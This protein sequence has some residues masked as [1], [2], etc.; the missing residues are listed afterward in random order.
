M[1]CRL[2]RFGRLL[3]ITVAVVGLFFNVG[4]GAQENGEALRA[5]VARIDITPE[6]PVKMSGYASRTSLS[7]GVHDPLSA[8]AIALEKDGRRLVLVNTDLIGFYNG[9]SDYLRRALLEELNLKPAELMLSAIHTHSAPS[10]TVDSENGH[11]NNLEYT[12][13]LK[14]KLIQLIREAQAKMGPV[15]MGA[16]VGYSPVGMNRRQTR[17]DGIGKE[18]V[19]YVRLGR[20]PYGPTDKEVL[21]LKIGEPDKAPK[22]VMFSYSTH[23]TSLGPR[24][25]MIGGDV[26]GLAEQFAEKIVGKGV[27][28]PGFA[29]ASGDI[30]PWF[31][32]LPG[33]NEEEGWI[34]EPVLLGTLLGEEVVHV[35]RSIDKLSPVGEINSAFVELAVPGKPE[36][37]VSVPE[38]HPQSV[39][40]LTVARVGDIAFVG[41]GGEVFSEIGLAV[42][43]ASPFRHTFV[44]TH[45]NGAAG[46]LPMAKYYK[47]GGYEVRSSSFAPE[48]AELVKK[49]VLEMLYSL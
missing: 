23:A 3:T 47:E 21:V 35:Y 34:P 15:Q 19:G 16:G 38:N 39:M 28:V 33:Y 2:F 36:D 5:G 10:L 46:Y 42:K 29:G 8:R 25:L 26:I 1:R 24:N 6:K 18:S 22:A 45:C 20:N 41:F 43:E 48:A 4:L 37:E 11:P 40:P 32:V 9:S 7:E 12:R 13:D 49:K 17:N 27:I 14:D 30:D 31:R 44:M